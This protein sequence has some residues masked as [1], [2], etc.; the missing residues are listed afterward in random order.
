[1]EKYIVANTDC[2]PESVYEIAWSTSKT[3]ADY[4]PGEYNILKYQHDTAEWHQKLRDVLLLLGPGL[5][6]KRSLWRVLL[7]GM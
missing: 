4:V 7:E 1:L 2:I 3:R 6:G 5:S